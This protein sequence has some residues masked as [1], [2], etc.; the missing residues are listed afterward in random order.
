MS[1]RTGHVVVTGRGM[2]TPLG[3]TARASTDA[4][5]KGGRA[6]RHTLS[7]LS[8]TS[9]SD[10]EVA[11]LPEF[12]ASAR[13]GN[14]RMLKFMSD[15]S[16][17]GCIAAK[18]ASAEAM[19]S[20]RFRPERIGLYAGAGLAAAN[21]DEVREMIQASI[22]EDGE[23]SCRLLGESGLRVASPLLSFKILPNIPACLIS[24]LECIRGPSLLFTPWEGQ[25]AAALL[26]AWQAV[27]DGEVD[28]AL[29]GASDNAT[30]P[31]TY[32]HLKQARLL[33]DGE[34]PA[35]GAAYLV[36]E[37]EET[38]VRDGQH[39]YA[40]IRRMELSQTDLGAFDP[41]AERMGRSFAAA[42]AILMALACET[43]EK[44]I[45]IRGVDRQEFRA[46][47]EEPE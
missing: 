10:A 25:T 20:K 8:G 17:L 42:P 21:V 6:T 37:R 13:I 43:Q 11:S 47:L 33:Q 7:E 26:E 2:L 34:I 35:P 23:F 32:I 19:I 40:R 9:I 1:V 16:V 30:H 38:A 24:I 18:E 27:D 45:M 3:A 4:W 41:L 28:C 31:A 46:V 14:R 22:D 29:A 12:N 5:Q 36:F 15:A 39:I 44:E